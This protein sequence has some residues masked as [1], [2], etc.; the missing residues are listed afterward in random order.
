[1]SSSLKRPASPSTESARPSKIVKD[2]EPILDLST[3]LDVSEL[4]SQVEIHA[5]FEKLATALLH[6]YYFCVHTGGNDG[7]EH[8][9]ELLEIEF[10][11]RTPTHADPF[12]HGTLEQSES[13]KW[14]VY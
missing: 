14:W 10:Y 9:F 6:D 1:M 5:R 11:L 12:A 8:A 3:L 4:S 2:A 13:G 7:V